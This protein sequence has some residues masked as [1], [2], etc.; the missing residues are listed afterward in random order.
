MAQKVK[1]EWD[2]FSCSLCLALPKAPVTTPCGHSDCRECIRDHWGAEEARGVDSCPQCSSTSKPRPV[3][4]TS[5]V[6]AAL[7][8]ALEKT[9]RQV[10]AAA[11]AADHCFA[12]VEDGACDVCAGRTLKAL[13]S[14]LDCRASYCNSHLQPHHRSSAFQRHRLV[15]PTQEPPRARVLFPR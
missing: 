1:L 14:C 4:E 6:L 2:T 15:E 5:T 11:A 8:A 9:G 13:K 10:A 7:V 12:R 3:L